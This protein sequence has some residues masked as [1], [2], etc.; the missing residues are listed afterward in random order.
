MLTGLL[1]SPLSLS[2]NCFCFR[3]EAERFTKPLLF[4]VPH[5]RARDP[6]TARALARAEQP[7]RVSAKNGDLERPFCLL[8][9]SSAA[10]EALER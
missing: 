3:S 6:H 1:F 4:G 5:A 9:T 2:H 10:R 8:A 7:S